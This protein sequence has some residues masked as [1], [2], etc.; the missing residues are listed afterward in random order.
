MPNRAN[1][2]AIL[3]KQQDINVAATLAELDK[4]QTIFT[5]R[6]A[7]TAELALSSIQTTIEQ[8]RKVQILAED[9]LQKIINFTRI[10]INDLKDRLTTLYTSYINQVI[11]PK[12]N[13]VIQDSLIVD[14]IDQ[15]QNNLDH[16][17]ITISRLLKNPIQDLVQIKYTA[18]KEQ[19]NILLKLLSL[20]S[21]LKT[22]QEQ[23][24]MQL[25]Q[26]ESA[27]VLQIL[28]IKNNFRERLRCTLNPDVVNDIMAE[29]KQQLQR[30]IIVERKAKQRLIADLEQL[31]NSTTQEV[32]QIIDNTKKAR[33]L[34]VKQL[35]ELASTISWQ[36]IG[37]EECACHD[38]KISLQPTLLNNDLSASKA[39]FSTLLF[40]NRV[41][42]QAVDKVI[43]P[44]TPKQTVNIKPAIN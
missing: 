17:L 26:Q 4:L 44:V 28:Q 30:I 34:T 6:L 10:D 1:N 16:H 39:S 32:D 14:I 3:F 23:L 43:L 38:I 18:T 27:A 22:G 29:L 20:I 37:I 36:L 40:T 21:D 33:Q 9:E 24:I 5:T 19:T 11:E 15:L 25:Q 7:S 12:A 2:K 42:E 8:H 13:N 41:T 35:Q 31:I